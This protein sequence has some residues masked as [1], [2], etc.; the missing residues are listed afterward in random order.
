MQL[1]RKVGRCPS[2]PPVVFCLTALAGSLLL[3]SALL[4]HP[5]PCLP[6][7]WRPAARRRR[8]AAGR[9]RRRL[10][11]RRRRPSQ[12]GAHQPSPADSQAQVLG[13]I[14]RRGGGWR[15]GRHSCSTA[16]DGAYCHGRLGPAPRAGSAACR[17]GLA[18]GAGAAPGGG[19]LAAA[20][21][22]A[23]R[24]GSGAGAGGRRCRGVPGVAAGGGARLGGPPATLGPRGAGRLCPC[25]AGA[26]P[27]A[28]D[29]AHAPR[30]I[31]QRAAGLHQAGEPVP[32]F[33]VCKA[34]TWLCQCATQPAQGGH[35]CGLCCLVL[36]Q[37]RRRAPETAAPRARTLLP[38]PPSLPCS[39]AAAPSRT[40]T[41]APRPAFTQAGLGGRLPCTRSHRARLAA[42][43]HDL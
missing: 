13:A 27:A 24:C 7:A 41:S 4:R 12:R 40:P 21:G 31:G 38:P 39:P 28:L 8:G 25:A 32:A 37:R 16:A 29:E 18:A 35:P 43:C 19:V 3:C 1:Q 30:V 36:I 9:A 33:A 20:A 42:C 10:G 14:G 6:P 11:Q 26:H 34:Q 22:A 15:A 2:L 23:R 5:L 17:S